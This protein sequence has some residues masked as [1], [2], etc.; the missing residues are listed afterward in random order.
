MHVVLIDVPRAR[1]A[2]ARI[3]LVSFLRWKDAGGKI[4]GLGSPTYSV[5]AGHRACA[6]ERSEVASPTPDAAH[7]GGPPHIR[8]AAS[9]AVRRMN[10]RTVS[11]NHGYDSGLVTRRSRTVYGPVLP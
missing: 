3:L 6:A 8:R 5:P 1:W 9:G 10:R 4:G 11:F 7:P 2:R